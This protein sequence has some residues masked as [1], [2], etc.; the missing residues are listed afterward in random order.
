MNRATGTTM[1]PMMSASAFRLLILATQ[2]MPC[3]SCWPFCAVLA[4]VFF[5]NLDVCMDIIIQ[6]SVCVVIIMVS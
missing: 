2:L 1:K 4:N 3:T 5:F 6:T